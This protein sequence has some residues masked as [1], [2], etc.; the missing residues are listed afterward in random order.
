MVTHSTILSWRIPQTEE[1]GGLWSRE[2][3]R[4]RDTA[5]QLTLSTFLNFLGLGIHLISF[6]TSVLLFLALRVLLVLR[7]LADFPIYSFGGAPF[8][9]C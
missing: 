2:S 4:V 1:P 9:A 6:C 8:T 3:Q 7:K 5:E